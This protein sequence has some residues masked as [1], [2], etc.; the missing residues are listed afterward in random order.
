MV[1]L[2]R[3][4]FFVFEKA[5]NVGRSDDDKRRKKREWPNKYARQISEKSLEQKSVAK[6]SSN[7]S[8]EIV[9]EFQK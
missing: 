7:S 5:K 6:S 4:F 8:C 2:R 9:L 3:Y 1:S